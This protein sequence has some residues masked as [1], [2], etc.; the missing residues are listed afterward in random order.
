MTVVNSVLR[1]TESIHIFVPCLF[2]VPLNAVLY[3]LFPSDFSAKNCV[4]NSH[5]SKKGSTFPTTSACMILP[6]RWREEITKL[7]NMQ[8]L[9]HILL[10]L[11]APPV[12]SIPLIHILGA[13]AKLQKPTVSFVMVFFFVFSSLSAW[14]ISLFLERFS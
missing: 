2:Y 1:K 11:S 5:F 9:Q 12:Y 13:F 6:S 14:N 8:L 3:L 10:T 4:C 7:P